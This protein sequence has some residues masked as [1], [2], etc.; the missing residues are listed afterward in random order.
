MAGPEYEPVQP[1]VPEG[2]VETPTQHEIPRDV[3]QATGAQ[4]VP[5][6][7]AQITDPV[8]GQVVAQPTIAPAD[9]QGPSITIPVYHDEEEIE[10]ATHGSVVDSS[11]WK[12]VGLLR[13]IH[14]A[15]RRGI[16][17]IF[18]QN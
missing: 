13:K 9:P 16:G 6:Q 14:M 15:V 17:I 18:N 3:E 7:P 10:K 12:A 1:R 4:A 8:S 11:T 2:V 5:A